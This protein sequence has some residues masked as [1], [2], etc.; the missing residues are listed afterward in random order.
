M[1]TP[2]QQQAYAELKALRL[3]EQAVRAMGAPTMLV[4]GQKQLDAL[5]DALAAVEDA[6]VGM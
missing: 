3:L 5:A 4:S 2:K 6:R 1:T